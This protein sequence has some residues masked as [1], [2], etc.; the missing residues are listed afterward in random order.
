VG[1][2]ALVAPFE[3]SV[4]DTDDGVVM[5]ASEGQQLAAKLLLEG[6]GDVKLVVLRSPTLEEA[7][8]SLFS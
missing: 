4:R 3:V 6:Y 2:R 1:V 8:L 7:L 5:Q